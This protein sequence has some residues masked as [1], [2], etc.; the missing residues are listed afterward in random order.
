MSLNAM[1]SLVCDQA[2]L[3]S[4]QSKE[5]G[6]A[7]HNKANVSQTVNGMAKQSATSE[8]NYFVL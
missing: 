8:N 6:P 7:S 2:K 4:K 3:E 1:C 5:E